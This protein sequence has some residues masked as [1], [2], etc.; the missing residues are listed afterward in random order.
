M[1]NIKIPFRL[2]LSLFVVIGLSGS[3]TKAFEITDD[4]DSVTYCLTSDRVGAGTYDLVSYRS[5]GGPRVGKPEYTSSHDGV[6]YYFVS[7]ENKEKFDKNPAKYLPKYGGWCSMTL[8]MGRLTTPDYLNYFIDEKGDLYFF[9]RTLSINGKEL[10]LR[11]IP[12]N[13]ATATKNYISFL[14]N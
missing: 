6:R 14:E 12:E 5:Q 3:E 4:P 9:E 7:L 2:F 10:W 11:N 1:E 8:A 13:K